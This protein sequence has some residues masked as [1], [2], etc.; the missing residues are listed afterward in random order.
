[1]GYVYMLSEDIMI[2]CQW[3]GNKSTAKEWNDN[4]YAECKSREMRRKYTPIYKERT[5]KRGANTFYKCPSC[6]TWSRGSQLKIA[7]MNNKDLLG[8]GGEPIIKVVKRKNN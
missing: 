1:M 7:D 4:T 2:L 8:L 3:C 6:G 5:F